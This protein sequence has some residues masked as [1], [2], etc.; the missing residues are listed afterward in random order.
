MRVLTI[1]HDLS[2]GGSERVA[3]RLAAEWR[4][5]GLESE[6]LL[7]SSDGVAEVP[8]GLPVNRLDPEVPRS[9]TSRF[10][11]GGA[12]R[13][14]VSAARPDIVFLPGNWHFALARGLARTRPRPVIVAKL[15]NPPLP[16]LLPGAGPFAVRTLRALLG[17]VDALAFWPEELS[18][19]LARLLPGMRLEPV[20]NP[21]VSVTIRARAPRPAEL[22]RHVL[23]AGRLVPQKHVA[24][25]VEAFAL[26]A[27][28]RDLRLTIAGD[29][30]ERADLERQVARLGLADRVAF[31]GHVADLAPVLD[32]ADILLVSSRFEGTPSVVFE[33]LAAGVPVVSTACSP[34]LPRLLDH[35]G[36]GRIVDGSDA[37]GLARAL[38]AQ[39][40]EPEPLG[41][42]TA[43]LAP[44]APEAIAARYGALFA[45][46]LSAPLRRAAE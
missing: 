11:I 30:P 25:A 37:A 17:P 34:V 39:L 24:R 45:D 16:A 4:R 33:A 46:L 13:S 27:A 14:A 32:S 36:R 3:L 19:E 21:P 7:V 31:L 8:A 9:L 44:H 38:L 23:V 1:L 20:P 35:P 15:S 42:V 40:D 22:A 10:R 6:L 2:A 43:L 12:L 26:A 18:G 5:L 29:G 41:D 28:S